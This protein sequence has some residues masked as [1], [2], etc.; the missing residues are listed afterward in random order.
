MSSVRKR[1]W[2]SES[3]QGCGLWPV[4]TDA[5][6]TLDEILFDLRGKNISELHTDQR[7]AAAA[8]VKR[9]YRLM[10]DKEDCEKYEKGL[11]V[12]SLA[13]R[14]LHLLAQDIFS[15]SILLSISNDNQLI[16]LVR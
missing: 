4:L 3:L 10:Y 2:C 12:L 6:R 1:L 15:G 5:C 13:K 7:N 16:S 8:K 9:G 14:D 11:K